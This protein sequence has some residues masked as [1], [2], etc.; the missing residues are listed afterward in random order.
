MICAITPPVGVVNQNIIL[1]G[2]VIMEC[3]N[4]P[5]QSRR[6]ARRQSRRDA[7]IDV[8]ARWFLEHGYAGTTMSAIASAVGG[9]KGTLWSYFPSKEELFSAVLDHATTEF[10][11][12]LSLTLQPAADVAD[13]LH[14]FCNSFLEKVLSPEAIALSRLVMGEAGRFPEVGRIFLE[15]GPRRTQKMLGLFLGQEM[16]RGLLRRDDEILAAQ[17]LISLCMS[18]LHQQMLLGAIDVPS[19]AAI[20]AEADR[21]VDIFMRAY[22]PPLPAPARQEEEAPA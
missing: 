1:Y 10:R 17:T 16:G 8:A 20:A 14:T 6:E 4:A 22:A 11:A 15:R 9:S 19:P 12:G 13:V 2:T 18:R 7:I 21:A 3:R 5:S